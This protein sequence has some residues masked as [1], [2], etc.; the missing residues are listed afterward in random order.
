[1][2]RNVSAWLHLYISS[3]KNTAFFSNYNAVLMTFFIKKMLNLRIFFGLLY[4]SFQLM[5]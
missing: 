4:Y 5:A 3:C 1:M 2:T